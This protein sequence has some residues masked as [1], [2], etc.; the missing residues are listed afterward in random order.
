VVRV[1]RPVIISRCR[2]LFAAFSASG[3]KGRFFNARIR[4]RFAFAPA[5]DGSP[6]PDPILRP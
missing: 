2:R 6:P 1:V 3:A 5:L 4:N